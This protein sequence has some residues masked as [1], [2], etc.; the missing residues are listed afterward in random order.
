MGTITNPGIVFEHPQ[1]ALL[2]LQEWAES[3]GET[4]VQAFCQNNLCELDKDE[5]VRRL[6]AK[7]PVPSSFDVIAFLFPGAGMSGANS[8][9]TEAPSPPETPGVAVKVQAEDVQTQDLRIAS[10]A[11]SS[12]MFA[13]GV[14]RPGERAFMDG[15]LKQAGLP[16]VEEVD[17][18][19]WRPSEVDRPAQPDA[20]IEAMVDLAFVDAQEDGSEWRVVREYARYW[21]YPLDELERLRKRADHRTASSMTRLWRSLRKLILTEKKS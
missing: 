12:V 21:R 14:V 18:R 16:P 8:R 2:A 4:D 10:Q 17:L 5:V 15:F 1:T 9:A 11:M 7:E 6:V 19:F 13:D 3:E 20:I